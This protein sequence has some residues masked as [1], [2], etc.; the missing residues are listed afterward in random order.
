[1]KVSTGKMDE[2]EL[3]SFVGQI[4]SLQ[5]QG[6]SGI[7]TIF[8]VMEETGK[9]RPIGEYPEHWVDSRHELEGG[10][11]SMAPDLSMG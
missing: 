2:G 3:R 8:S 1:M 6:S 9:T 10:L 7:Q 11:T 4:S 5:A